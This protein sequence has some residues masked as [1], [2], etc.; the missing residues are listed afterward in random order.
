MAD[1]TI[2]DFTLT[3]DT[4]DTDVIYFVRGTGPGRDRYQTKAQF[5]QSI[6]SDSIATDA[7]ITDLIEEKTV[8]VGVTIGN[9]LKVAV[10]E[11]VVEDDGIT[12]TNKITAQA[13]HYTAG[14]HGTMTS[15]AAFAIIEP[16]IE[17]GQTILVFGAYGTGPTKVSRAYRLDA[18][19]ITFYGLNGTTPATGNITSGGGGTTGYSISW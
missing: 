12:F 18:N 15:A 3:T 6:T 14:I 9:V 13:R 1:K 11:E 7:I 10:I 19:T 17:I 5:L 16:Y 8:G 4:E 2:L